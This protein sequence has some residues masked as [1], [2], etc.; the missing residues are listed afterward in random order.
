MAFLGAAIGRA[1][2]TGAS[3]LSTAISRAALANRERDAAE[4]DRL[5]R[6][7]QHKDELALRTRQLDQDQDQ[8]AA[9]EDRAWTTSGYRST[10]APALS[11]VV[12]QAYTA[13]AMVVKPKLPNFGQALM[14]QAQGKVTRTYDQS[15]DPQA[16]R[17]SASDAA[18][19]A[20]SAADNAAAAERLRLQLTSQE[21]QAAA[22]RESNAEVARINS[23]TG[24]ERIDEQYAWRRQN[25]VADISAMVTRGHR[26]R[27]ATV[28]WLAGNYPDLPVEMQAEIVEHFHP[29][30]SATALRQQTATSAGE[31]AY[32]DLIT[33]AN[34]RGRGIS[35]DSATALTGYRPGAASGN[36]AE[37]A[38]PANYFQPTPADSPQLREWKISAAEAQRRGIPSSQWPPRPAR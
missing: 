12:E 1:L 7:Q 30:P 5:F 28:A 17:Q 15:I 24:A 6:E 29:T 34:S 25:A 26:N 21:Q 4:K 37:Q 33:G 23:R 20:R 19:S 8:F 36:T 27:E 35:P 2:G 13:P 10:P 11:Q 9:T 38:A 16:I 31:K 22:D 32:Y 3:D 14:D 18:A